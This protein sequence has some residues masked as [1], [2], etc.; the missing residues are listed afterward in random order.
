ME[1]PKQNHKKVIPQAANAVTEKPKT[2]DIDIKP[3]NAIHKFLIK[4][5]L[6]PGKRHFEIKPQRVINV[7]RIAGVA[8]PIAEELNFNHK[9][10][11]ASLNK[12][13]KKHSEDIFY[14]VAC[15][16]QNDHREPTSKMI[17]IV[18]NEFEME[19]LEKVLIVGVNNYNLNSFT[20]TIALITGIE[21]LNL[22]ASPQDE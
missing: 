8:M 20:R 1:K 12:I 4:R 13:M 21:A 18:R 17:D 5:K 14:I 10:R 7:A 15:V 9:D 22:K 11:I 2:F 16:L 19:D 6:M 3:K